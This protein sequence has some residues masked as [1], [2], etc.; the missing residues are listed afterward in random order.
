MYVFGRRNGSR[1]RTP[2]LVPDFKSG[3]SACSAI[4]R[5]LMVAGADLRL[6]G[7]ACYLG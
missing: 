2:L 1:T 6:G 7:D 4:L 5:G 3:A